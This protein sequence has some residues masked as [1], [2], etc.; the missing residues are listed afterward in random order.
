M[1]EKKLEVDVDAEMFEKHVLT[2]YN[3]LKSMDDKKDKK[4]KSGSK[5]IQLY[6]AEDG[7]HLA[8]VNNS[9]VL[10]MG[11]VLYSS[12]F[13]TY[14]LETGGSD[15]LPLSVNLDK[16]MTAFGG[17]SGTVSMELIPDKQRLN[18]T[19]GIFH[20]GLGLKKVQ[21]KEPKYPKISLNNSFSMKGEEYS[22]IIN[23][24]SAFS[25]YI[26]VEVT[27]NPVDENDF[28]VR[29]VSKD[30]NTN[31]NISV[32]IDKYDLIDNSGLNEASKVYIDSRNTG[33]L[34]VIRSVIS[35]SI[36]EV[37]IKTKSGMP[38]EISYEVGEG[39]GK[40]SIMLAPRGSSEE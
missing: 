7:L 34:N 28:N 15:Y 31:E 6:F 27:E 22:N 24:C 25:P 36:P 19:S 23:K 35:S 5:N 33:Y 18:I 38:L 2:P 17:S 4:G 13:D 12:A 39:L 29:F 20:Y 10:F 21:N 26:T 37:E 3:V 9:N 14:E 11:T 40:S 8:E 1:S 30:T 16:M 32:D